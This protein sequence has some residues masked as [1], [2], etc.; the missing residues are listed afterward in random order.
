MVL[1]PLAFDNALYVSL[2][3]RPDDRDEILATQPW[4]G[5][6]ACFARQ[7]VEHAGPL[8]WCAG[9]SRP[10]A[11][12]GARELWPGVFQAW[13][14]ATADF[15]SIGISL[16]LAVRRAIM[17]AVAAAGAH[18]VQAFSAAWH[19]QAHAWLERLGA[20]REST[21]RAFGRNG[22]DFF[23]YCWTDKEARHV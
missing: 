19:T 8:A 23:T 14:F 17:P 21:L 18:R 20:E 1:Q 13:M 16:T 11:C 6:A 12:I 10:I 15:D 22:E 2:H 5:T 3:M 7:A 4:G 9:R